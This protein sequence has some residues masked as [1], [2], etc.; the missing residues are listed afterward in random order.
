MGR[1]LD[2]IGTADNPL[3]GLVARRLALAGPGHR[4]VPVAAIDGPSYDLWAEGVW[5]KPEDA[6]F[7]AVGELGRRRGRRQGPRARAAGNAAAQAMQ[8]RTQLQPFSGEEIAPPVAYPTART[9][10]SARASPALAAMLAAGLP[11]RCAALSSPGDFD[12][13]DDQAEGFDSDVCKVTADTIAAF[14]AD[15]EARG[16]ADR[17]DHP[18]LVG[19]RP[20]PGGERLR[21]RPRRRRRRVRDRHAG[22]AAR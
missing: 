13:H 17:V 10:G 18:G 3:Q 4:S 1:L 11:I 22:R 21:H 15:L 6:M 20:P 16:L 12:T 19:V 5:G 2:R 9:A 8:L 14:Q 7:G